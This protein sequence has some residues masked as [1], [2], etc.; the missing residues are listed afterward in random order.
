M[1]ERVQRE[2]YRE[3]YNVDTDIHTDTLHSICWSA[4]YFPSACQTLIMIILS[5]EYKS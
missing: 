3:I 4:L 2:I 5:L 1:Y